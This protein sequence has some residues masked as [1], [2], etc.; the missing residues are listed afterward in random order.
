[1]EYF[2]F[3]EE[4]PTAGAGGQNRWQEG[5]LNWLNGQ[6]DPRYHPPSEYCG[7]GNPISV[8]FVSPSDH[9]SNLPN[10]FNIKFKIDSTADIIE[11][12]LEIDGTKVRGYSGPP[13]E[14]EATLSDGIHTIKARAKDAN[15]KE[16]DRTITVGVKTSWEASSTPAP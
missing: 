14:Y 2:V 4:D 5:I 1:V 7:S 3:K 11:A 12:S 9:D 16:S 10:T 6:A 15:G 8:D 13:Y